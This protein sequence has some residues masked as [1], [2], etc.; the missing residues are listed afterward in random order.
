M[1]ADAPM[2]SDSLRELQRHLGRAPPPPD[3]VAEVLKTVRT[4]L[5]AND[6]AAV[7]PLL[8]TLIKRAGETAE[9]LTL[10]GHAHRQAQS[11]TAADRAFVAARRLD[12]TDPMLALAAAQ[13]RYQLG[14][15]AA[16]AFL[17][18]GQMQVPIQGHLQRVALGNAA[19]ARVSEGDAAGGVALLQAELARHPDWMEGHRLLSRLL[20]VTDPGADGDVA[21]VAALAAMP[22]HRELWLAW[23]QT[24]AQVRDWTK[25]RDILDRAEAACG[26]GRDLQAARL[27]LAT[28]GGTPDEASRMLAQTADLQGDG[29][30]LCRVRAL[31]RQGRAAEA[32]DL[33]WLQTRGPSAMTF[34]PY[35]SLAW[36]MTGDRRAAWLDGSPPRVRSVDLPFDRRERAALADLL[37]RLHTLERPYAEQSVRGGT[38]TDRS[39]LLRGEPELQRLRRRMLEGVAD[40][41]AGLPAQEDGHPLLGLR[42][43]RLRIEGSWSVRLAGQGFN[44]A[45]TH[46]AGWISAVF[47]VALPEPEQMGPSPAGWIT[48]GEPPP[49]LG[50]PLKAYAE[51]EPRPGRL[52]LFPSYMW[53]GTRPFADGERLVV[54]FDMQRAAPGAA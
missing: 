54:A 6:G 33:A 1:A 9:V 31:L 14:R 3:L 2:P 10:L 39:V 22:T 5:A 51:V 20:W 43:D 13:T 45:H 42:R 24:A 28:E 7:I 32:A 47:Y 21:L 19:Q 37:R 4:R 46:P 23:F 41:V 25:A 29:V 27:F 36:R 12:P 17:A 8:E 18:A 26:D 11:L 53:H 44:V 38:Q 16:D 35:L 52:V 30:A 34:W 40:Y 50:L 49:E 15:P 48:F